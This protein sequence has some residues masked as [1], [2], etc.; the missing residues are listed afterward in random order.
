MD[1]FGLTSRVSMFLPD[2]GLASWDPVGTNSTFKIC[3]P[4][5][6]RT[7]ALLIWKHFRLGEEGTGMG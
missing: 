6:S 5:S 3:S 7:K 1:Q 4:H 2:E